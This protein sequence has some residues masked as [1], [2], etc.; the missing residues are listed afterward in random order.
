MLLSKLVRA[1]RQAPRELFEGQVFP[2]TTTA[3]V[4]VAA[5]GGFDLLPPCER[6]SIRDRPESGRETDFE[7]GAEGARGVISAIRWTRRQHGSGL[8][9]V[10][11]G[12]RETAAH[13]VDVSLGRVTGELRGF[14]FALPSNRVLRVGESARIRAARVLMPPQA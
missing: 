14:E 3:V 8:A 9:T 2:Q 5:A 12:L 10:A 13:V 7:K 1:P 11:P 4:R 6:E